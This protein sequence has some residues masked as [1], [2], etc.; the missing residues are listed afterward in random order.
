VTELTV[1]GRYILGLLAP[2]GQ[3]AI[4][5][6]EEDL[7]DQTELP[8]AGED[9]KAKKTPKKFTKPANA[10]PT[11]KPNWPRKKVNHG[12][13]SKPMLPCRKLWPSPRTTLSRGITEASPACIP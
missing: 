2:K 8:V 3:T 1:R 11:S 12:D 5:T 10:L 4:L 7:E 6:E 13:R 9:T